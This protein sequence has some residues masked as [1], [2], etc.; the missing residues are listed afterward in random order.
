M[1]GRSYGRHMAAGAVRRLFHQT[2]GF[3]SMTARAMARQASGTIVSLVVP[4]H[5][6]VRVVAGETGELAS[7]CLKTAASGQVRR[8]MTHTP[9]R[10]P[11][12]LLQVP[13]HAVA[14]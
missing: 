14:T 3:G 13:G 8:L 1:R 12:D 7:T 2:D 9:R 5:R 11:V 10:L 6:V 4:A